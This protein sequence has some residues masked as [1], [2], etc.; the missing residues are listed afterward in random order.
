MTYNHHKQLSVPFCELIDFIV[1][2]SVKTHLKQLAV[3]KLREY[4]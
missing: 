1:Q 4:A 3:I 2:F